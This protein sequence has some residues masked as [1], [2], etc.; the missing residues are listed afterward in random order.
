MPHSPACIWKE[1][2]SSY[3]LT[4]FDGERP[5]CTHCNHSNSL[6]IPWNLSFRGSSACFCSSNCMQIYGAQV[7]LWSDRRRTLR[8]FGSNRELRDSNHVYVHLI[9]CSMQL[10]QP[11]IV[12]CVGNWQ[13][14]QCMGG[15]LASSIIAMESILQHLNTGGIWYGV[16]GSVP[17]RV[18]NLAPSATNH[19]L[20]R[21]TKHGICLLAGFGRAWWWTRGHSRYRSATKFGSLLPS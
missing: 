5:S 12:M 1:K 14:F 15:G 8:V 11:A 4:H 2:R 13:W 18:A 16:V 17:Q 19:G 7:V 10:L 21:R 20:I 9:G 6:C 3:Q